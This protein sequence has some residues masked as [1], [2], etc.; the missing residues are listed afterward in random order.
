MVHIKKSFVL[1]L[2]IHKNEEEKTLSTLD[3]QRQIADGEWKKKK[4]LIVFKQ[5]RIFW[6]SP[7]IHPRGLD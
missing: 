6:L 3:A 2:N 5:V 1:F 4:E 7:H